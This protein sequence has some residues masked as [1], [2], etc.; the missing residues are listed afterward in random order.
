MNYVANLSCGKD[1]LAMV[2]RLMKEKKPLSHY[3]YFDTGAEFQAIYDILEKI[4]PILNNYGCQLI[5]L[6]PDTNLY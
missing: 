4:R 5:T 2:L 3:I 1:S 6:K